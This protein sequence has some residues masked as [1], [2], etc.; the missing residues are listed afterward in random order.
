MPSLITKLVGVNF[1]SKALQI[2]KLLEPGHPLLLVREPNNPYDPNAI[3]VYIKL[4]HIDSN[5]AAQIAAR[6]DHNEPLN[7]HERTCTT[8]RL[9]SGGQ[10]EAEVP[11]DH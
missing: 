2:K 10:I 7:S 8:G 4:G 5:N 6:I 9:C 11:D 3:E 1:Y